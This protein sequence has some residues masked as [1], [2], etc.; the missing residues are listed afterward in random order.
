LWRSRA[1]TSPKRKKRWM[2]ARFVFCNHPHPVPF[3]GSYPAVSLL[4]VVVVVVVNDC[5]MARTVW[6]PTE[7]FIILY[8]Q[9]HVWSLRGRKR[10]P[11][12]VVAGGITKITPERS[13]GIVEFR[14]YAEKRCGWD[15]MQNRCAFYRVTYV[16]ASV[17]FS[18]MY[19]TNNVGCL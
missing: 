12:A 9:M 10:D 7:L 3:V 5:V 2:T 1:L 8:M 19:V 14:I 15:N 6:G 18:S 17:F 13:K 4:Y 16:W 11:Y